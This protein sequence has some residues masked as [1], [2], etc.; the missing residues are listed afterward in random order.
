MEIKSRLTFKK[1]IHKYNDVFYDAKRIAL[2]SFSG[3][4]SKQSSN[5][6][7]ATVINLSTVT[8]FGNYM[9]LFNNIN[10]M[11]WTVMQNV[12]AGVGDL[13]ATS[14]KEQVYKVYREILSFSFYIQVVIAFGLLVL[15][16]DFITLWLGQEYVLEPGVLYL[17]V[18]CLVFGAFT[19][20]NTCFLAAYRFF[21]DAWM[22]VLEAFLTVG[23]GILLAFKFGI[24]GVM[25][26]IL[27][28]ILLMFFWKPYYLHKKVFGNYIS[29]Y[30]VAVGKMFLFSA[31]IYLGM[32]HIV[33]E[34][35]KIY[36]GITT[37]GEWFVWAFVCVGVFAVVLAVI[38][39]IFDTGFSTFVKRLTLLRKK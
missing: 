29:S 20:A 4:I 36:L 39:T 2:Q 28:G 14:P 34:P 23:M 8:Y 12:W 6:I 32:N 37:W 9:M 1:L 38:L 26:G 21:N 33:V 17:L 16:Q 7:I 19:N 18:A 30:F 3:Y 24:L 5:I 10:M 15:T 22:S 11:I 13:V 25:I 27:I 31:I 35:L